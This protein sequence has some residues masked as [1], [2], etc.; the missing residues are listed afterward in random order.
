MILSLG[1]QI[2]DTFKLRK[3]VPPDKRVYF[4]SLAGNF[5]TRRAQD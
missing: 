5:L 2:G 4:S 3:K 1:T